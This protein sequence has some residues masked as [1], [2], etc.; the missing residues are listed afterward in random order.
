MVM[1]KLTTKFIDQCRDCFSKSFYWGAVAVLESQFPESWL[2]PTIHWPI[3]D[4]ISDY[5]TNKRAVVVLPRDWLKSQVCSIYYPIWRAMLDA[6]FTSLIVQNT[7]TNAT[8]KITAIRSVLKNNQ[9]LQ[10]LYPERMPT[11]GCKQSSEAIELPRQAPLADATFEGAGVGTATTS[12]HFELL[13][14]DDTV[15]PEFDRMSPEVCEPSE[16]QVVKAVGFHRQAHFLLHDLKT[17]Q[18]LV[19]C[20]RWRELDLISWIRRELSDRYL[21]IERA[22]RE[23]ASGQPDPDGELTYPQRFDDDV[24]KEIHQTV[25]DYMFQAL[26]MNSPLAGKDAIFHREDL[27]L[28]DRA[29]QDLMVFTTVDPAPPE[30]KGLDPDYNVVMTCGVSVS[31][32]RIFILDYFRERCTPGEVIEALFNHVDRFRPLKVG[33]ESVA[34]Q[35]ALEW[36]VKEE[37]NKRR[38]WFMIEPLRTSNMKKIARIRGL[39]PIVRNKALFLREWME[40]LRQEFVSFP[41]GA[42]DDLLDALA[43][44][45]QFWSHTELL[46]EEQRNEEFD[47]FTGAAILEELHGRMKRPVGYPYDMMGVTKDGQSLAAAAQQGNP[48]LLFAGSYQLGAT[49]INHGFGYT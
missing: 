1:E 11:S 3:C 44:Q 12:R 20:T 14:E 29:S 21:F 47:R 40:D 10:M 48:N 41:R 2:S 13:V 39:Q 35:K 33:I 30:S 27:Q 4:A 34:Y 5:R 28:Y 6:N 31:T 17:S 22:V 9:L 37:M 25:G 46:Q 23:N 16:E 15:A 8:N 19:V 42:H 36:F 7:F 18:R 32:G 45:I 49:R 24:L 38:V 43:Y 26:M